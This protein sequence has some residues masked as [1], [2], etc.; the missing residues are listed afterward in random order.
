VAAGRPAP[1][2]PQQGEVSAIRARSNGFDLQVRSP[3]GGTV[4]SS[5]SYLP[6]WRSEIDGRESPAFEVNSGF[7]GFAVPPGT[8]RVRLDYR[9][10]GWRLGLLLAALA[11]SLAVLAGLAGAIARRRT[12][13]KGSEG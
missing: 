1:P 7:L 8:H 10:A 2:V 5:V 4:A 9:P 6:G 11:A 13:K 3:A 12:T